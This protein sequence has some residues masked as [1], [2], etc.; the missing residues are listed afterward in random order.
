M[1]NETLNTVCEAS[2]LFISFNESRLRR[3][4]AQPTCFSCNSV[5]CLR[6]SRIS[7]CIC[8]VAAPTKKKHIGKKAK[9]AGRHHSEFEPV[10]AKSAVSEMKAQ[11]AA[12]V[13]WPSVCFIRLSISV[14]VLICERKCCLALQ[15]CC[16]HSG[17]AALLFRAAL[18]SL[19]LG[20]ALF[21]GVVA[22]CHR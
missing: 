18:G 2:A 19:F 16:R 1:F 5:S 7:R 10:E 17:K 13:Q 3:H 4:S 12:G 11:N 15:S 9:N 6:S 14:M 8:D 20:D 21:G 22:E